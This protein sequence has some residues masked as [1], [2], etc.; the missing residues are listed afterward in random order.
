M[1]TIFTYFVTLIAIG[2]SV[3]ITLFFKL[4]LERMFREK[5]SVIAFHI[6]N[7]LIVLMVSYAFYAVFTIYIFERDLNLLLQMLINLVI[8]LPIYIIGNILFEKNKFKFRKY[9]PAEDG[10]VLVINEKYLKKK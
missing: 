3:F 2:I 4:E 10:K 5:T 9:R 1:Q 7:V 6:C 8:I